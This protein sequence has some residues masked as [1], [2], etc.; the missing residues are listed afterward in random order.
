MPETARTALAIRH[1]AFEDL[2]LLA[3]LLAARDIAARYV[4]AGID[5]LAAIDAL[6]PD[7]MVV[8]GGP[9]G[10]YD[11]ADY[12]W[13]AD[14]LRLLERRLAKDRPTLGICLG[15][16]MMAA[17][18]GARVYPM[19]VKEIGWSPLSLTD[20]GRASDLAPLDRAAVLHWHGDTFDM[21]AGA[22]H[23]AATPVC[24][25]QAFSYGARALAL[26][27][28]AEATGRGLE[29][30]FIG[31]ACEIGAADGVTVAGLRADTAR[32]AAA[33]EAAGRAAIGRWLDR[34]APA[35]GKTR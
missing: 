24:A 9:I 7:L 25:H 35:S 30:W 10:V 6:A 20:A 14:T 21:P 19:G 13:I 27:F 12:P 4:E 16:Q 11:S 34:V 15:A 32:D 28:H 17:A 5:D 29:R 18:L 22:V 3:D 31:H 2:G 26:Q 33:C 8:L 23:L 1:V